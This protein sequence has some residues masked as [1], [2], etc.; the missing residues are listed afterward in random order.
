MR[1]FIRI[2]GARLAHEERGFTLIELMIAMSI[3]GIL[4]AISLPT[5][6]GFKDIANKTAATANVNSLIPDIEQYSS[7]N[8][9]GV[10]TSQD[11][12]WNGT[13]ATNVGTNADS[14]YTGLTIAILKSKYDS[15]IT[16]A[17]YSW[18]VN[19][20]GSSTT[21]CLY[22]T[23]GQWYAAKK[24]PNNTVTVGKNMVQST[25]TAS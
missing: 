18:N 8:Y 21:Y 25:C 7:D 16:T 10:P 23:S 19:F 5:Y 24:G 6:A 9:S 14:G 17:N 1:T 22:T 13:D 20:T 12:D 3:M 4:M 2:L 11:P 15:S